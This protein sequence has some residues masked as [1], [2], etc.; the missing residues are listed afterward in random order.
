M[1]S[2]WSRGCGSPL[3]SARSSTCAVRQAGA[4]RRSRPWTA[5]LHAT[6][7]EPAVVERRLRR[8]AGQRGVTRGRLLLA[9]AEPGAASPGETRLRL[10]VVDAG[11]P[12]PRA[13]VPSHDDAGGWL[14]T[15][16]LGWDEILL[17][18][19]YEGDVHLRG[20]SPSRDRRRFNLLELRAGS[21]VVLRYGA[22]E[23]ARPRLVVGDV[24]EVMRVRCP[25]ML[26]GLIA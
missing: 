6:G 25:A 2:A 13:Q 18:L 1:T 3:P 20:T 15:H 23:V 19:E 12:R 7:V 14:A 4:W 21:R 17:F 24:T 10:V 5:V 11:L 22:A 8:M 26:Q 9:D 16:D